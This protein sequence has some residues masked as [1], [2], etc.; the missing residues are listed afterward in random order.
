MSKTKQTKYNARP[1]DKII[2]SPSGGELVFTDDRVDGPESGYGALKSVEAQAIDLVVGRG[3]GLP[4]EAK[5]N[6]VAVNM[7]FMSDAARIYISQLSDVDNN[8]SLVKGKVGNI[9]ASSV[10]AVKADSVRI[11]GRKGIKIVTGGS[12]DSRGQKIMEVAGIDLI[13]GNND[14]DLQSLVKGENLIAYLKSLHGLIDQVQEQVFSLQK[15]LN[16][17]ITTDYVLHTH[18]TA[19]GPTTPHLLAL[20]SGI[21]VS[22]NVIDNIKTNQGYIETAIQLKLKGLSPGDKN[23]ICSLYNTTN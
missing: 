21:E 16:K 22:K 15:Q 11:V 10:I 13:A 5:K 18:G 20:K 6:A 2:E 7:D 1:S 9:K 8:L 12:I 4:P 17:F 23:Y 14:K 19:V 3:S